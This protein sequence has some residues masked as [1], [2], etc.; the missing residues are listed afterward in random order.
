MDFS[1]FST[2]VCEKTVSQTEQEIKAR[3]SQVDAEINFTNKV[4]GKPI[5]VKTFLSLQESISNTRESAAV[6]ESL[7]D[8]LN[9]TS[10]SFEPIKDIQ[11]LIS[12]SVSFGCLNKSPTNVD[13]NVTVSN[14]KFPMSVKV[15]AGTIIQGRSG[16]AT[17]HGAVGTNTKQGRPV[18]VTQQTSLASRKQVRVM[19]TPL[20]PTF[21]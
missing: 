19:K 12:Q 13:V 5:N 15:S 10:L 14:I 8:S 11:K 9:R 7:K 20:H 4:K 16:L 3:I 17:H 2:K 1:I 18:L 21:I 6:I